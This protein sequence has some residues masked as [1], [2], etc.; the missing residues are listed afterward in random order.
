[1]LEGLSNGE[2]FIRGKFSLDFVLERSFKLDDFLLL[3]A[4][5]SN[6]L[7]YLPFEVT[8]IGI[9]RDFELFDQ[10]CVQK[11]AGQSI[12]IQFLLVALQQ[13]GESPLV[14]L[15]HAQLIKDLLLDQIA[16]ETPV[17]A[18]TAHF[19]EPEEDGELGWLMAKNGKGQVQSI[20]VLKL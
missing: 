13:N 7:L 19:G 17:K 8:K 14:E 18:P 5:S 3:L 11:V 10:T 15:Q 12:D 20:L 16:D 4:K 1:M 2:G 9:N 6:V